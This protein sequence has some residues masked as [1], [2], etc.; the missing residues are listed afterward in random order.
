[1][2]VFIDT[3]N[4]IWKF[5]SENTLLIIAFTIVPVGIFSV[6]TSIFVLLKQLSSNRNLPVMKVIAEEQAA[7]LNKYEND[8]AE[9][10]DYEED[11]SSDVD[12]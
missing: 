7:K 4:E 8:N 6:I 9:V 12:F 2:Q 10:D 1:M 5:I 11:S 3:I